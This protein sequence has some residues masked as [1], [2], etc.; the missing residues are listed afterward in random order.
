[1]RFSERSRICLCPFGAKTNPRFFFSRSLRA[2]IED[3]CPE[4]SV[5]SSDSRVFLTFFSH[6]FFSAPFMGREKQ[7]PHLWIGKKNLAMNGSGKTSCLSFRFLV[8]FSEGKKANFFLFLRK[9]KKF[10]FFPSEK[11]TRNRKERQDVFPSAPQGQREKTRESEKIRPFSERKRTGKKKSWICLCPF[12]ALDKS[13]IGAPANCT[14]FA[15][16]PINDFS[17]PGIGKSIEIGGTAVPSDSL[18]I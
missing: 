3:R 17:F 5:V 8:L 18:G 7:L 9:R 13:G 10:A 14:Q 15:G 11:R 2:P 12:G 6:V 16:A 4:R 1:M